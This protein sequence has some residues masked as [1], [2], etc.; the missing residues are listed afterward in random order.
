[1]AEELSAIGIDDIKAE[2]RKIL[3]KK[4]YVHS[5]G[6]AGEA[7]KLARRYGADPA[8]AYL[9]GLVHDCAKEYPP[10]EMETILKTEYGVAVDSMSRIMPKILHGPLGAC[11]AQR[12]F[13][14]YDPEIL[15][16]VKYHTTGKGGMRIL[17]KIIYIADY[18][19]PNRD[20]DGVKE[21][22]E[23]AYDNIDEAI[24]HGID[25]TIKDLIRRGLVI[26]P[27]TMHARNDLIMKRG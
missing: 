14:I 9:A 20:F 24:I 21:L 2:L 19:E 15:D 23:T 12:K 25:E 3:S 7:E 5:L 22:R 1:M 4:R 27:D 11:D 6:V 26:H 17:T 8:K 18:I 13:G 10:E 16:A